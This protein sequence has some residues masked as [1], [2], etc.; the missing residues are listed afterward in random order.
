MTRNPD[1]TDPQHYTYG[2]DVHGSVSQLLGNDGQTSAPYGYDPYGEEDTTLTKGD[3]ATNDV[4]ITNP[5]R[6]SAKR[7][8]TGSQTIDMGARRF[9]P[10]TSR[11][12]QADLYRG[13]LSDLSLST[14]PLTQNRYALAG[15]NPVS[16]VEA[17][18]HAVYF[19]GYGSAKSAR[20]NGSSTKRIREVAGNAWMGQ[21]EV[22]VTANPE[23]IVEDMPGTTHADVQVKRNPNYYYGLHPDEPRS[24]WVPDRDYGGE[25]LDILSWAPGLGTLT[26]G[27]R[28]IADSSD[29]ASH[30]AGAIPGKLGKIPDA[31]RM[32]K[33]GDE[34]GEVASHADEATRGVPDD[35][36][37][38]RGGTK[39]LPPSGEVFSGAA[40]R[41]LRDAAAGVPH[42]QIRATTAGEIRA[43]GGSVELFRELTRA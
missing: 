40:G 37:V 42:G 32:L 33:F 1:A 23:W 25:L 16:F 22:G 7:Y 9:S 12:L 17:D 15:G 2:Y 34:A 38:V 4:N 3:P 13:A 6:Y 39:D 24:K 20:K 36:T 18:G 10:D 43:T 11:F 31:V 41:Y 8:D 19:N 27:I 14:D 35:F 28:C 30:C 26:E 29:R 21:E 5:F